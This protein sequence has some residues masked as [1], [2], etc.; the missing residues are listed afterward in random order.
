MG[1][2]RVSRYSSRIAVTSI[3]SWMTA[4]Y[5]QRAKALRGAAVLAPTT[6]QFCWPSGAYVDYGHTPPGPRPHGRDIFVRGTGV[7][8]YEQTVVTANVDVNGEPRWGFERNVNAGT[9]LPVDGLTPNG[10][11]SE[12]ISGV[13]DA[14][15]RRERTVR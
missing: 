13:R 4:H 3:Q 11:P 8:P 9:L 15:Q 7:G 1:P 5:C 10:Q 6:G 2:F 14:G 12:L